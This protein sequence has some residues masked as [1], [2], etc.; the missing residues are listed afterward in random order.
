MCIQF[1]CA[2]VVFGAM[3]MTLS[4]AEPEVETPATSPTTAAATQPAAPRM[5]RFSFVILRSAENPPKISREEA[6]EIQKQHI[7]HLKA[8]HDAG[9]LVIAGPLGDQPDKTMRGF[10]I[11]REQV[12]MA[13]QLA[14]QDPAVKAGRLR[15]EVMSWYVEKGYM[16]FPKAPSR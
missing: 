7:G 16:T 8:M 1:L 15:V 6:T 12:E 13:K 5:E 4:A 3:A 11:Y 10:C 14:E 2:A 9:H